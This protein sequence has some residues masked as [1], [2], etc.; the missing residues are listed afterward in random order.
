KEQLGLEEALDFFLRE[1]VVLQ[2]VDDRAHALL[3][4]AHAIAFHLRRL[5]AGNEGPGSGPHPEDALVFELGVRL[6]D[7]V[8]ADDDLL[9]QR[10]DSRKAVAGLQYAGVDRVANLLGELKV[11]RLCG[12]RVDAE[13]HQTTV[14]LLGYSD[15]N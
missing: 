5:P 14:S 8:W 15:T 3:C 11:E 12:R 13:V 1:A 4:L 10:A 7:R 2:P 6:D 9:R